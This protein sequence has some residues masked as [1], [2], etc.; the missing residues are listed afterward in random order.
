M[1]KVDGFPFHQDFY[2][3]RST[4]D[5]HRLVFLQ[6]SGAESPIPW[7]ASMPVLFIGAEPNER[8]HMVTEVS[9]GPT[10]QVP[11]VIDIVICMI[12]ELYVLGPFGKP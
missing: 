10:W 2:E 12:S 6:S 3:L 9:S 11:M 5:D 8:Q 4:F 1:G 7:L